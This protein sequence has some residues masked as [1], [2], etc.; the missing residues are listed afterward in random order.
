MNRANKGLENYSELCDYVVTKTDRGSRF[1]LQ[2]IFLIVSASYESLFPHQP[3]VSLSREPLNEL[4]NLCCLVGVAL[5]YNEYIY[6][7]ILKRSN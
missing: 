3:Q 2:T 4:I 7:G 6:N 5:S 1:R